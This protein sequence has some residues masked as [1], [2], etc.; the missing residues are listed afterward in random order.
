MVDPHAGSLLSDLRGVLHVGDHQKLFDM[1]WHQRVAYLL[2]AVLAWGQIPGSSGLDQSRVL[3]TS[4]GQL[5]AMAIYLTWLGQLPLKQWLCFGV[6]LR[7]DGLDGHEWDSPHHQLLLCSF[8]IFQDQR[9][10]VG[11][12]TNE[13]SR[14]YSQRTKNCVNWPWKNQYY[15]HN[16]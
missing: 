9:A 14:C 16:G 12:W 5:S 8:G 15:H 7:G 3:C 10:L 6:Q 1:D 2:L 11:C 13:G 4:R